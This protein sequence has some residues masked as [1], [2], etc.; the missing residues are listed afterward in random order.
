MN[1]GFSTYPDDYL[2]DKE[3]LEAVGNH[4]VATVLHPLDVYTTEFRP[5]IEKYIGPD[6]IRIFKCVKPDPVGDFLDILHDRA[7]AQH[8]ARGGERIYRDLPDPSNNAD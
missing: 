1:P 7:C 8:R 3:A 5:Y 2:A 4:R 6:Y